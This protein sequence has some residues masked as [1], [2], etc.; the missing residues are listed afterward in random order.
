MRLIDADKLKYI[1]RGLPLDG[2]ITILG[3]TS[4]IRIID[5]MPTVA[6]YGHWMLRTDGSDE[7][8]TVTYKCSVCKRISSKP[9]ERCPYCKAEM[10][11]GVTYE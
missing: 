3:A 9:S 10:N 4:V 2:T 7:D 8:F 1:V 6:K 5:S 11:K